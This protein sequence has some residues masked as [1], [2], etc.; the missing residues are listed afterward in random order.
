MDV[1]KGFSCQQLHWLLGHRSPHSAQPESLRQHVCPVTLQHFDVLQFTPAAEQESRSG[2]TCTDCLTCTRPSP[3]SLGAERTSREAAGASNSRPPMA[4]ATPTL[5]AQAGRGGE[6]LG[7]TASEPSLS[8]LLRLP[9]TV[10]E[11]ARAGIAA[12]AVSAGTAQ[13]AGGQVA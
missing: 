7:P 4:T 8:E 5:R 12:L 1:Q 11:K 9:S 3:A 10:G 2:T 13:G 6:W